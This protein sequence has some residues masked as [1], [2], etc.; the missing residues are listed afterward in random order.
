MKRTVSSVNKRLALCSIIAALA[1]VLSYLEAISGINA[2]MPVIGTKL[3]LGNIAVVVAAFAVS[4]PCGLVISLI[5][6]GVMAMLFGTPTSFVFSLFGAML[7]YAFIAFS[8]LVI[9]D[10]ISLIGVSVGASAMHMTG[11][12]IAASLMLGSADIFNLLGVYL[13]MSVASGIV[14]GA[15]AQLCT[16]KLKKITGA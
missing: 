2:L 3:G 15:I 5:R 13:L 9:K 7:A 4:L 6:V 14:T 12:L 16:S 8:K 11:Q 1:I 10:K